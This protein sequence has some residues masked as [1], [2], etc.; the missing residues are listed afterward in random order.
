M[1]LEQGAADVTE[2]EQV[3]KL[4]ADAEEA[5]DFLKAFVVQAKLNERGNFG[6]QDHAIHSMPVL[7][8][9]QGEQR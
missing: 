3:T 2:Q 1:L 6:E 4:L 7:S 8:T 5:A 9:H